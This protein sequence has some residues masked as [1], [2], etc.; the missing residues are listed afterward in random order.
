MVYKQRAGLTIQSVDDEMLILDLSTDK[1]HQLNPTACFIWSKCDG[2]SDE[3][4]LAALLSDHYEVDMKT[5][6]RDVERNGT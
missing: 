5:A 3:K 1:I 6:Q 2:T 4:Q